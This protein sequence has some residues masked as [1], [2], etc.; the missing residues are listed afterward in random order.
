MYAVITHCR[1]ASENARSA[2]ADGSAMFMTVASSAIINW[3]SEM[4]SRAIHRRS[5]RG[6]AASRSDVLLMAAPPVRFGTCRD[7]RT[8]SALPFVGERAE[9]GQPF[10]VPSRGAPGAKQQQQ[11]RWL[12][13]LLAERADAAFR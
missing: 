9:P 2:W 13:G 10:E 6:G 8:N 7:G 3:A 12:P 4:N 11:R 1:S 5:T